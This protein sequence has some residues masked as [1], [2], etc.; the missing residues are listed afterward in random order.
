MK[1]RIEIET[2]EPSPNIASLVSFVA[3]QAVRTHGSN[4]DD[5]RL[6]TLNG[7][8]RLDG[9]SV[10]NKSLTVLEAALARFELSNVSKGGMKYTPEDSGPAYS[11]T[12]LLE[13]AP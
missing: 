4:N 10:D 12:F 5:V 11:L 2:N 7:D 3:E 6:E 9:I 13:T 1:I 8:V